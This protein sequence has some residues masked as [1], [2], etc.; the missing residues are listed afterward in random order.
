MTI[1]HDGWTLP[2]TKP[3]GVSCGEWSHKGCL[4][5]HAHRH[6]EWKGMV[7][8]KTYRKSCFKPSCEL[9]VKKWAGRGS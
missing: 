6:S 2:S 4:D 7:F 8:V 9:C 3:K 1:T 5:V